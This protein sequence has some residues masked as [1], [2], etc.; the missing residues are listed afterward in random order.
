M[1]TITC[2]N[3]FGH[4]VCL[5][6][7]KFVFRPSVYGIACKDGKVLLIKGKSNGK[8]WL[9]GGGVEIGEMLRDALSREFQEETGLIILEETFLKVLENFF[10]YE[11]TDE[12]M[13]SHLFLFEVSVGNGVLK[14]GSAIDDGE[15]ESSSW[16]PIVNL[17]PSDFSSCGE[18]LCS[19]LYSY[20]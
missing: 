16:V 5:P 13:H 6:K 2:L 4:T 15:A 9:P 8:F 7:E 17:Q 12:A 10:Y 19:L 1:D 14:E 11:P 20:V 18:D 3:N